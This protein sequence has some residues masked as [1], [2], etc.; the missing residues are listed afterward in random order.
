[1]LDLARGVRD[2][3]LTACDTVEYHWPEKFAKIPCISYY[4]LHNGEYRHADDGEY[5]SEIHF[6]VDVWAK[7]GVAASEL[8]ARV[9]DAMRAI[10]FTRQ[11]SHDI[12]DG[13]KLRRKNM[14]FKTIR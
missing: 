1:M 9:S 6:N 11:N 14:T 3:L 7:T 13:S 12:H 10:G 4:E 2:A 5:M 8:A